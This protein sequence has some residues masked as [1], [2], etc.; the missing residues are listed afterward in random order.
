MR[1]SQA[2]RDESSVKKQFIRLSASFAALQG[3]SRTTLVGA[4]RQPTPSMGFRPLRHMQQARSGS[5]GLRIPATF[6]PQ[7]LATLSTNCALASLAG[8]VSRRRRPWGFALRS[9]LL[10]CGSAAFLPSFAPRVVTAD[11]LSSIERPTRAN[12]KPDFRVLPQGNPLPRDGCLVRCTAGCSRGFFPFR[13]FRDAALT[14]ASVRL[15]SRAY[16]QA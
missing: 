8:F 15:L 2:S 16:R 9:F 4:S 5:R 10:P 13:G 6:R 7:G 3:I 11:S 1:S 12:P 14:D